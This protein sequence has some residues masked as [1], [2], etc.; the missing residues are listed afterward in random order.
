MF[1]HQGVGG[2]EINSKGF[3]LNEILTTDMIHDDVAMAF[4]GHYHSFKQASHNLI[5]PGSTMQLNWGDQGEPR[6]WLEVTTD[7]GQVTGIEF[8]HSPASRFVT[9][10]EANL[11]LADD[12]VG[13]FVRVVSRGDYSPEELSR[14]IMGAGAASCEIKVVRGENKP[15][16]VR[17]SMTSFN[18]VVYS[19]AAAKEDL[20]VIDA[21][22]RAVGDRL[23]SDHYHLPEV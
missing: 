6:G 3:T 18:E 9:V 5:V 23:I 17:P 11:E 22:D 21:Y 7:Q 19:F 14:A 15:V 8:F 13:N 16:T 10:N 12:I 2:V 4:A 20:G 1:L